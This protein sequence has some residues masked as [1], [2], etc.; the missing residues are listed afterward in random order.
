MQEFSK[1]N[2]YVKPISRTLR[3]KESEME[4]ATFKWFHQKI[5]VW[6]YLNFYGF[7]HI[8]TSNQSLGSSI[9]FWEGKGKNILT[10]F[11]Y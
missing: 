3:Y 1:Q 7:L 6:L 8:Q 4:N 9:N 5:T 11:Y 2:T 10:V